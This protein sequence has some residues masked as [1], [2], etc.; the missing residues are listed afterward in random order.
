MKD[1]SVV[2]LGGGP[3]SRDPR[4]RKE[5]A[6]QRSEPVASW[7][8]RATEAVAEG[9]FD[10]GV[11]ICRKVLAHAP[12]NAAALELL[13]HVRVAVIRQAALATYEGRAHACLVAA[14]DRVMAGGQLEDALV[15][16]QQFQPAH[17]AITEALHELRAEMSGDVRERLDATE[18]ERRWH[19][20]EAE[21]AR[22]EALAARFSRLLTEI[23][24][25]EHQDAPTPA[26]EPVETVQ[27]ARA[28]RVTQAPTFGISDETPRSRLAYLM[29]PAMAM[30]ILAAG[31]ATLS[32][33]G[34]WAGLP[35]IQETHAASQAQASP[36][37]MTTVPDPSTVIQEPRPPEVKPQETTTVVPPVVPVSDQPPRPVAEAPLPPSAAAASAA[38]GATK[39]TALPD[40]RS[41]ASAPVPSG[42]KQKTPVPLK[43][44]DG[45]KTAAPS[46]A[47]GQARFDSRPSGAD[48][49]IDGVVRGRTPLALSLP[50]GTHALELRGEAGSRSLSLQI[51]EGV[52]VSHHA[53]LFAQPTYLTTDI[54][55]KPSGVKDPSGWLS[56]NASPWADVFIDGRSVGSTPL[57][58]LAV[59]IGD[60]EIVWTHPQ[61][62]QRRQTVS[63]TAETPARVSVDLA[64]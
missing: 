64:R 61:L 59:S 28:A 1:A 23:Q 25:T 5:M 52:L 3:R 13:E 19:H 21:V 62:G 27:T 29:R 35:S 6:R 31:V 42:D 50:V 40:V 58:N 17:P 32:R 18:A 48:V 7:L 54:A 33:P 47:T 26:A 51:A 37:A 55:S 56:V 36:E 49:L 2:Q 34:R 4:D 46:V 12:Q 14:R 44:V 30:L 22:H 11:A 20:I 57:A 45:P 63:V 39:A 41:V 10:A 9:D 38:T 43:T 60:H 53:D 16:L 24:D 15:I 8:L